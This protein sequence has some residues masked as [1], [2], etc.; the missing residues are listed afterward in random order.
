MPYF[1]FEF[2]EFRIYLI[3]F[4]RN[5]GNDINWS[6][7]NGHLFFFTITLKLCWQR[8]WVY[9]EFFI[10]CAISFLTSWRVKFLWYVL[11]CNFKNNQHFSLEILEIIWN[12]LFMFSIYRVLNTKTNWEKCG[13]F[14]T[15]RIC[16]VRICRDY[17]IL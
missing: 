2:V 12:W 15:L 6:V 8:C 11:Q 1:Y 14:H 3:D 5:K 13:D 9:V 10:V 16:R 4:M 7:L 17:C